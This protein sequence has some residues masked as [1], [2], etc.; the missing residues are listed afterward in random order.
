MYKLLATIFPGGY[1]FLVVNLVAYFCAD[2]VSDIFSSSFLTISLLATFSGMAVSTQSHVMGRRLPLV[3]RVYLVLIFLCLSAFPCFWLWDGGLE[4]Y[5][6]ALLAAL[7]YSIFEVT[8]S[9]IA[10]EGLFERLVLS[11]FISV[12]LLVPN[13]Y[14]FQDKS[15]LLVLFTF[16]SLMVPVLFVKG[17]GESSHR[18]NLDVIKDVGSYSLSNGVSTGVSFALPLLLVTEYGDGGATVIVQVFTLSA[19]FMFYPRYLSAGFLVSFKKYGNWKEVFQFEKKVFIYVAMV[20]L[21]YVIIS[22]IFF[23]EYY[24]LLP[25]FIAVVSSQLA[26]PYSNVMMVRG[27]GR[28]MLRVNIFGFLVL[29]FLL[30]LV[31]GVSD[32]GESRAEIILWCY[33]AYVVIRAFFLRKACFKV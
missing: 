2:E 31:Y 18:L 23:L 12:L 32:S 17:G 20:S 13:L 29:L 16:L 22:A 14:F 5:A 7:G 30:A 33:A 15:L 27:A 3:E 21:G 6:V 24:K 4:S 9:E 8:R 28:E 10:S 26:L 25:L 1:R 11:G 19:L